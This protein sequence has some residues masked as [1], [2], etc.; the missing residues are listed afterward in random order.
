MC[1]VEH[2]ILKWLGE[3]GMDDLRCHREDRWL[4]RL[5]RVD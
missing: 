3:E 5:K 4:N 2:W 1:G